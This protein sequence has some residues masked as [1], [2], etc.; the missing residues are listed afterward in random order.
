[1]L[2]RKIYNYIKK[3]FEQGSERVLIIDGARQIG[4]SYAI[5]Y[6][7][8]AMFKNYLEINLLQDRQGAGLFEQAKTVQ[9][10]YLQLGMLAGNKMGN[11]ENTLVFLDEIQEYPHLLTLLK[12]LRQ[13]NR[14]TYIASGSLLGVTLAQTVSIP[15][16]SIEVKHMYPMDF[17][18]FLWANGV[19]EESV[20]ILRQKFENRESLDEPTHLQMMDFFKKYLLTGGL[21]AAVKAFVQ[22]QNIVKVRDIQKEIHHYYALDAA[23]Y[24][25]EHKLKIKRIFEMIPSTLENKKKRVVVK[26]IENKQGKRFSNY[27]EE[28]DYLVNAGI[29]LEV[30]AVSNPVF[31]LTETSGKNLLKLYLNDVGLLTQI[32][33]GTNIRAVLDTQNSV[34]L[35]SVYE[36]AVACELRAHGFNLFYYDNKTKGEVDYLID[37]FNTLSVMP[38]EVKSG[39]DYT[40]HSALNHFV[41]NGDYPVKTAY[42]LS[43][44]QQIKQKGKVLYMPVYNVM[45]LDIQVRQE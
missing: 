42:V 10:F 17:E 43:N 28:F 34:N 27:Q 8:K 20:G 23:K 33:Y 32:L 16:G 31:P 7:G 3:Y 35:G 44:E 1:M 9:D 11:K 24:D 39:K 14:F 21:P 5:R 29:A 13:E 30:R 40:V 15:I 19:G 18:E 2:N 25:F 6:V 41:N 45:F 38:I 12:F 22:T 37:D 36:C 4:K 26:D